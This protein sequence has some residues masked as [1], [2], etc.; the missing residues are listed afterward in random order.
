MAITKN[1]IKI[2]FGLHQY[3]QTYIEA[4]PGYGEAEA[5][6]LNS[7]SHNSTSTLGDLRVG[8]LFMNRSLA[9]FISIGAIICSAA[10]LLGHSF[11]AKEA[12]VVDASTPYEIKIGVTPSSLSN[13]RQ[14]LIRMIWGA[15]TL[16]AGWPNL[17]EEGAAKILASMPVA[18]Q[19]VASL[20]A[21]MDS[22][23]Y[24]WKN[25]GAK[26]AV[27]HGGHGT[28][29]ADP[30]LLSKLWSDGWSVLY[31]NMPLEGGNARPIVQH[32]KFGNFQLLSHAHL[33]LVDLAG[34][35]LLQVFMQPIVEAL[36]KATEEARMDRVAM[37]GFS[38]GGWATTL[39]AALDKRID[40]SV[41]IAGSLPM[42]LRNA[43]PFKSLGDAEQ[44]YPP[45]LAIVDYLDLY[46]MATDGGRKQLQILNKRDPCCFR[47]EQAEIY[48]SSVRSASHGVGGAWN[49]W[50]DDSHAKHAVSAAAE[51]RVLSFLKASN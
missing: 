12:S 25:V 45:L 51:D 44:I 7:P 27:H 19:W 4:A 37:V 33:Q 23:I 46:V 28:Q 32:P 39:Y 3:L 9:T 40:V 6:A 42:F 2:H 1:W 48:V 22:R 38:G 29:L 18:S 41:Q 50:V 14:D 43:A 21:G 16:P 8:R 31:V 35:S 11:S 34:Y 47:G 24:Y 49:L 5:P 26:L 13:I 10:I 20:P 17:R 36:N 30:S 15:D